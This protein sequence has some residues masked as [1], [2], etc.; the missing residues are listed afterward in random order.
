MPKNPHHTPFQGGQKMK[1]GLTVE[2]WAHGEKSIANVM[3]PEQKSVLVSVQHSSADHTV[4]IFLG[5]PGQAPILSLVV[6]TDGLA[7]EV[8]PAKQEDP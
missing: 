5:T 2:T 7:L 8:I 1:S 4:S 3:I 6:K